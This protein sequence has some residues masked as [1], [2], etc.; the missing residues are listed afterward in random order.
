VSE[1][2]PNTLI[3]DRY[4]LGEQLGRGG[5][6]VVYRAR[7]SVLDRDVAVKLLSASGLG[8]EGRERMLREAQ[9]IAKLNHPNIVQV[10]DAGQLEP[11]TGSPPGMA[12]QAGEAI[13]FI[14]M[15]LVQGPSLHDRPPQD[16]EGIVGVARQICAALE[17]AHSHGIIHRDLKPENVLIGPDGT[18]KLMD[19]G[20]ARSVASRLTTEGEITGTVFYL[21]PEI[22]LGHD[23]DGRA[24]LYSLGVM[25]YEFTAGILPFAD[26]DPLAIISQ[27][28]HASVVPP[29]AHREGISPAMNALILRLLSKRP[30]D[31][32]ASAAEVAQ[33]LDHLEAGEVI[34]LE[35]RE[36]SLLDRF[37]RGRLV[38]RDRE[39]GEARAFWHRATQGQGQV[40]L[41]SG[42]PGVGKTRLVRELAT[43]VEVSGGSVLVGECYAEGGAPYAPMAQMIRAALSLGVTRSLPNPVLA[44]LATI[45]PDLRTRHPDLPSNQPLDPQAEKQR[46]FESVTAMATSLADQT[47]L[48]LILDDAHW[49]DGGTLSL[50]R[51]L[52]RRLR[53]SR[54]LV[55]AAYREIELDE[56]L[57]LTELLHDL[58]RERLAKRIKLTRLDRQE[59]RDLLAALFR[60]EITPEFLDGIYRETEGNPFFIEEVCKAL[61][62]SGKLY[63][64]DGRWHRPGVDE[65]DIPQSVRLAVQARVRRLPETTQETLQLAATLGREFDYQTLSQASDM[66]E[67][68]LI[69][70]LERAQRAQLIE[71]LSTGREV[72]FSF[73]HALIPS[74]LYEGISALRRRPM[75]RRAAESIEALRPDD[76]ESLAH[77]FAAAGDRVRAI[78]YCRKA[79]GRSNGLHTYDASKRYLTTALGLLDAG[80]MPETRLGLLEELADAHTML[81]EPGEAIP[82]Y[83]EALEVWQGLP[84]AITLTAIR[85]HRKIVDTVAWMTWYADRQR[86]EGTAQSSQQAGLKLIE[87]QTPDRE[88]VRF[89]IALSYFA[90]AERGSPDWDET[91]RCAQAALAIAQQ[92]SDPGT[93]SA[94]LDALERVYGARGLFRERLQVSLE[95]LALSQDSLFGDLQ[96]RTKILLGTSWSYHHVGE[97]A[98]A[99][100]YGEQA[101]SLAQEIRAVDLQVAALRSQAFSWF[102]LDRWD[103]LL[104]IDAKWRGLEQAYVN[105]FQRI[106]PMCFMI[107]LDAS[108][109]ALRGEHNEAARLRA[110][111]H[112]IMSEATGPPERWGRDNHY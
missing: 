6:G 12:G 91:E 58:D 71:E 32:P 4:Q 90:S 87:G 42:E 74:T 55:V 81:G 93:L 19:F 61:I 95:R 48:L 47:P 41:I 24:D 75:H 36:L 89:W 101:E 77:H 105:F 109:H 67:Q 38:G 112:T 7:D 106:G 11:S 50:L 84:S 69:E 21:P 31:R 57:P 76:Y 39:L 49:A 83:Q 33:A 10:H 85:L 14:V 110:H 30:E 20:L 23:I 82:H 52:A 65:M 100:P 27:H 78:E 46:L 96:E 44:D 64:E 15:E 70:A 45:S 103:K 73:T 72:S 5:M 26:G 94:A 17:H 22:A 80:E 28:L 86:F 97:F 16:F 54:T 104:E 2:G 1:A 29:R 79:A 102:R 40:L 60:E 63:F 37:V 68:M 3:N 9:A 59:T 34:D 18:A 56:A 35:V 66:D 108:V 8:T 62:D 51:H 99:I 92:L 53:Q 88:I 111:S 43:W 13:P 25:L 107:G 98:Q